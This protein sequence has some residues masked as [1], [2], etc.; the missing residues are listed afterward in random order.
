MAADDGPRETILRDAKYERVIRSLLY[1]DITETVKQYLSSPIRDARILAKGRARLNSLLESADDPT[2]KSNMRHQIAT[3]D[4]F[5]SA[6]NSLGLGGLQ[7]E[8]VSNENTALLIEG[9]KI[10][11]WPTVWLRQARPKGADLVGALMLDFAKGLPLR[12]DAARQKALTAM[13]FTTYLLHRK[14]A[15]ERCSD[16][17]KV[18]GSLCVMHHLHR[19]E[20]VSA[21]DNYRNKLKNMEAVCRA[22]FRQWDTILPPAQYDPSDATIRS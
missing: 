22:I 6:L 1:R 8:M 21:P 14:V 2:R 10:S 9:V 18:S 11:V 7:A 17:S 20:S 15:A 5:E 13:E 4:A 19:G 12:T 16:G 3:L